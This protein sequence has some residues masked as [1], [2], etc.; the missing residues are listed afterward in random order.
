[1]AENNDSIGSGGIPPT[2]IN[3]AE[4]VK[5][6]AKKLIENSKDIDPD[7]RAYVNKHWWELIGNEVSKEVDRK[8]M[9][10]ISTPPVN[11]PEEPHTGRHDF[12]S[13]ELSGETFLEVGGGTGK[14]FVYGDYYSIN[15]LQRKLH[16]FEK[17]EKENKALYQRLADQEELLR[18]FVKETRNMLNRGE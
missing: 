15:L 18:R 2:P 13:A 14:H 11:P 3:E 7:I 1:M 12:K 10:L 17:L 4:I 5:N 8:A 9:E 16:H 6:F